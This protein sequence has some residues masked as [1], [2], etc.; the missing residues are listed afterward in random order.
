MSILLRIYNNIKY[1][2]NDPV[3]LAIKK[4]DKFDVNENSKIIDIGAHKGNISEYFL[5]KGCK[6][7]AYEPNP[8]LKDKLK[9]IEKRYKKLIFYPMGISNKNGKIN[10]YFKFDKYENKIKFDS[11]GNSIMNE[12][13]NVSQTEYSKIDCI[14]FKT[15]VQT[16]G[17]VDIIKIDIEGG[18]YLIYKDILKYSNYFNHCILET[19]ETKLSKNYLDIH[20]KMVKEINMHPNKDKFDLNYI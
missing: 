14:D 10:Y 5:K 15:L 7:F 13:K 8:Y 12:K 20:L 2:L 3:K 9:K 16:T 1:R 19:H 17:K 6:V 4:L 18:E 11:E